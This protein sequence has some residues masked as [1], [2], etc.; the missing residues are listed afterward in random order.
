MSEKNSFYETYK[1]IRKDWGD[2][3]P[4]TKTIENKKKYKRKEKHPKKFIEDSFDEI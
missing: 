4:T 2:I 3:K 1:K